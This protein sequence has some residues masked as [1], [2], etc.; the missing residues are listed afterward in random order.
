M[1]CDT[2]FAAVCA[3]WPV[4]R[5]LLLGMALAAGLGMLLLAAWWM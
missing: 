4:Q 2:E 1:I 5:K 3:G